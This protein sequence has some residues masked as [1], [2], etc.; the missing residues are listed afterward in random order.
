M[1]LKVWIEKVRE[2]E[3]MVKEY[4]A[5]LGIFQILLSLNYIRKDQYADKRWTI[6]AGGLPV[7]FIQYVEDNE[8]QLA[9]ALE[10]V[11]RGIEKVKFQG[12]TIDIVHTLAVVSGYLYP[13]AV[14]NYWIGWGRE[15]A[16]LTQEAH[17]YQEDHQCN[18]EEAALE[19][20]EKSNVKTHVSLL[21][22]CADAVKIARL[23]RYNAL[24]DALHKY[25]YQD[26]HYLKRSHYLFSNLG[27]CYKEKVTEKKL[28]EKMQGQMEEIHDYFGQDLYDQLA[29]TVPLETRRTCCHAYAKLI[30]EKI[31]LHKG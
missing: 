28:I 6:L 19:V 2:I 4:D 11:L 7:E 1:D 18:S 22:S 24:S 8:P 31:P 5:G 10:D 12:D 13:K 9:E 25:Y 20:I 29:P 21:D 26:E 14:P 30:V 15:L 23:C 17:Q 27:L 3:K 16:L